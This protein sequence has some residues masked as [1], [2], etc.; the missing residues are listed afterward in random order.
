[1]AKGPAPT[2]KWTVLL[3]MAGDNNLSE[4]CVYSLTQIREA[5]AK[6]SSKLKVLAQ[7]D[8][9]TV[10]VQTK[11]YRLRAGETLDDDAKATG[12]KAQETDSG[13][14]QSLLEFLRWG[15]SECPAEHYMVVLVGHGSGTDTDYLLH[16]DNP[17]GALSILDLRYVFT[18]LSDDGHTIDI[19]GFDTCLMSMCEVCFE[20]LRTNVTYLVGSEGFSP[21]TGWPYKEILQELSKQVEGTATSNPNVTTPL[22][23]ARYIVEQYQ[24]FYDPYRNG[25]ISVDQSV[26]EVKKIDEVKKRMFVMVG[27]LLEEFEAGE[28]NYGYAKQN[29][30]L[31]A[32]WDTQSYN[33]EMFV[34]LY[35]FCERLRERYIQFKQTSKVIDS[36]LEVQKAIAD[37]VL[38]SCVSGPAFQF[39][40]G[41]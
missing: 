36:S 5:L 38:R 18:Q 33:G 24:K 14:S 29:A 20:L 19:L 35:D 7:F 34:D 9:A 22:A 10:R 41:I 12:W 26:I 1:M 31:L 4:E 8:P 27:D 21:N 17:P 15:I 37:L 23:L 40:F 3:Y 32:H 28:L 16:D 25:A 6:D 2:A 39:S 13:E 11:R 30:L